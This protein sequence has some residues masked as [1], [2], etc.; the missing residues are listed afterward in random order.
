MFELEVQ[1]FTCQRSLMRCVRVLGFCNPKH[2]VTLA[3]G[4]ACSSNTRLQLAVSAAEA[5]LRESD[6]VMG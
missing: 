3:A 4:L 2:K 5:F 1:A 6:K